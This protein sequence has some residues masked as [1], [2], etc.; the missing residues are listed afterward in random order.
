MQRVVAKLVMTLAPT[1]ST[2]GLIKPYKPGPAVEH[3]NP[4][5]KLSVVVEPVAVFD[6][7]FGILMRQTTCPFLL[8]GMGPLNEFT[9]PGLAA[10][11]GPV[12]CEAASETT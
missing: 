7:P 1:A 6:A 5:D 3:H 4:V 9:I 8:A 10:L 2:Y 11:C 12:F